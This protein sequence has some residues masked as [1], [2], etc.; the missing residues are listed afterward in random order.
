M[1]AVNDVSQYATT[2]LDNTTQWLN[3]PNIATVLIIVLVL[4]ASFFTGRFS[5]AVLL[6]FNSALVQ[7]IS[8]FLIIYLA[9]KNLA[10]GLAALIA[11]FAILIRI[12]RTTELFS[13]MD[14]DQD[15]T[16]YPVKYSNRRYS[17]PASAR[18]S[19]C[20]TNAMD[21]LNGAPGVEPQEAPPVA[22]DATDTVLNAPEPE[23]HPHHALLS[24]LAEDEKSVYSPANF[25]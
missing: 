16:Q 24:G 18:R 4:F 2:T 1:N 7:M 3:N 23:E 8:F 9:H 15:N 13:A 20:F 11:M 12:S 5:P 17:V 21:S 6:F 10:L 19:K 22:D 25:S 14:P